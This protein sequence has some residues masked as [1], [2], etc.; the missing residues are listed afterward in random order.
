MCINIKKPELKQRLP[1]EFECYKV[2]FKTQD[3]IYL[4]PW[5]GAEIKI[6]KNRSH[7]AVKRRFDIVVPA[8]LDYDPGIHVFLTLQD[9]RSY[10]DFPHFPGYQMVILKGTAKKR[11]IKTIGLLSQLSSEYLTIA[12]KYLT[13][14]SKYLAGASKYLA[15]AAVG[16]VDF[17]EELPYYAT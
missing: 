17:T 16:T 10:G 4:A 5:T 12:S 9:A 7:R 13:G 8:L 1:N 3:K 6:G 11:S 2:V 15:V 14:V